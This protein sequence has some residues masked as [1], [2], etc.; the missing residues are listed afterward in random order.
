MTRDGR[1]GLPIIPPTK[2][3]VQRMLKG[4]T[5]KPGEVVWDG[6]PPRNGVVTVEIVAATGVMAGAKPEHM[7]LLLAIVE[8]MKTVP[9]IGKGM[10]CPDHH[11]PSH[12]PADHR[13]RPDRQ[14]T[15]YWLR[16]RSDGTGDAGQ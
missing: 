3:A 2:E 5:H 7:P 1:I 16:H 12:G 15:G 11:N 13:Q 6:I 9:K 14:G 10:A 8:A 4:T